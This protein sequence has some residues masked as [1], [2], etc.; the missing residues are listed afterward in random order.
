M[1]TVVAIVVSFWRLVLTVMVGWRPRW[2]DTDDFWVA[3][4]GRNAA[5]RG[6]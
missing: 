4:I 2:G 3:R 1:I 5:I 6:T